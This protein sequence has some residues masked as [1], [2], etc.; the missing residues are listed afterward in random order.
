MGDLHSLN[1]SR[2]NHQ[3]K[4]KQLIK[5]TTR[6]KQTLFIIL[7]YLNQFYDNLQKICS[8]SPLRPSHNKSSPHARGE[9]MSALLVIKTR[10]RSTTTK[11]SLVE[12]F[13]WWIGCFQIISIP[14]R[15]SNIL[16]QSSS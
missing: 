4:L 6:G 5:F 13:L 16:Q 2:V 7:T 9:L 14:A 3:F 12:F 15:K 10:N 8:I 11:I 1:T